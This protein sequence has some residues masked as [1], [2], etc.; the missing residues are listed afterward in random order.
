MLM[1]GLHSVPQ[2]LEYLNRKCFVINPFE[3]SKPQECFRG[4][5]RALCTFWSLL[6]PYIDISE[7]TLLHPSLLMPSVLHLLLS[8]TLSVLS[9]LRPTPLVM[10]LA[11]QFALHLS[12]KETG[13]T[14]PWT[15]GG[16]VV[17]TLSLNMTGLLWDAFA[18]SCPKML[19]S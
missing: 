13:G 4:L 9:P 16:G 11:M 2:G 6:R 14:F 17:W 12:L 7:T 18:V 3:D 1:K 10:S 15:G 5:H 8:D 19:L